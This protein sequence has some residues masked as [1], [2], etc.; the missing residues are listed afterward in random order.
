MDSIS[1][2]WPMNS[3]HLN[4][5]GLPPAS[6][7]HHGRGED[8]HHTPSL[9]SNG[10]DADSICPLQRS[11]SQNRAAAGIFLVYALPGFDVRIVGPDIGVWY[12]NGSL[13]WKSPLAEVTAAELFEVVE[14]L[15]TT[16][17]AFL[18]EKPIRKA[19]AIGTWVVAADRKRKVAAVV[20]FD[21]VRF[22]DGTS[23]HVDDCSDPVPAPA[24]WA[25]VRMAEVL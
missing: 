24:T 13:G 17:R 22:E 4:A 12:P 7:D 16:W 21:R 10:T 18:A 5:V 14:R 1:T 23:A 15:T 3:V 25:T 6:E 20:G 2:G 11:V 19:P 9:N 8:L